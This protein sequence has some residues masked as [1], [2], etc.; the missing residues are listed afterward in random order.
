MNITATVLSLTLIFLGIVTIY[1]SFWAF[2]N[3]RISG[4]LE[5]ALFMLSVSIY[6]FGY[7]IEISHTD[8]PSVLLAIKVEYTGIPYMSYFALLFTF[9][10]ITGKPLNRTIVIVLVIIPVI[11]TLL[12]YIIELHNLFYINPRVV[13]ERFFPVLKFKKGIIYIIRFVY[14]QL[15]ALA[16]I[17]FLLTRL[18]IEKKGRKAQIISL[19]AAQMIPGIIALFY[20]SGMIPGGL[21]INPFSSFIVGVIFSIAILKFGLFE[22]VTHGREVALDSI[23]E[24][25][26]LFDNSGII[27][28]LNSSARNLQFINL[29]TGAPLPDNNK[30]SVMLQSALDDGKKRFEYIY[31]LSRTQKLFYRINIYESKRGIAVIIHD[32]T[33]TMQLMN[34][35][36]YKASFDY[37]TNIRN[38]RSI[39]ESAVKE[40]NISKD[41]KRP[42]SFIMADIDYF[43][44]LND[45]FGH[46]FGDK[47]LIK[48]AASLT[49]ILRTIDLVGR[50]GGDELLIICPD[51]DQING[52]STAEKLR[53]EINKIEMKHENTLINISCSFGVHTYSNTEI[54]SNIDELITK[55]DKALYESKKNGRNK[56]SYSH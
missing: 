22:I 30:F 20:I 38:R 29:K 16:S 33:E 51:T 8:L 3:R 47:V 42:I 52:I 32:F 24:A 56:V 18:F 45:E 4:A 50:Y 40:L 17:I 46:I 9:R 2:N 14:Q 49:T 43:K 27:H 36:K 13:N 19:I 55:A 41:K 25:F 1:F 53:S 10:F 21:D 12:V 35:L 44:S 39:I 54:N 7:A 11:S 15:L 23:G 28:D 5:F 48:I 31:N 34:R 37:L 26:I 6:T